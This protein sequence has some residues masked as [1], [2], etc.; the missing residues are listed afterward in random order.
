MIFGT[1]KQP[2]CAPRRVGQRRAATGSC[3]LERLEHVVAQR[4][5]ER[6]RVGHRRRRPRRRADRAA[7]CSR[8]WRRARASAARPPRRSSS[9][10]ASVAVSR[11]SASVILVGMGLPKTSTRSARRRPSTAHVDGAPPSTGGGIE[12]RATSCPLAPDDDVDDVVLRLRDLREALGAGDHVLLVA[13]RLVD[14]HEAV[15]GAVVGVVLVG[16]GCG[17]RRGTRTRACSWPASPAC[18]RAGRGRAA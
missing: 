5:I 4:Q 16:T 8:G 1:S 17:R 7:P 10:R 9:R 13:A 18:R 6:H 14:D 2:S 12:T 3:R 11:T 15:P